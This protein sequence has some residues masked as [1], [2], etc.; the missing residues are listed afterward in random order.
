MLRD[1]RRRAV[2]IELPGAALDIDR[3]SDLD[4]FWRRG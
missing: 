2:G 3:R 1:P 4:D